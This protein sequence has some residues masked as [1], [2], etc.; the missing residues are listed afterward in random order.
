MATR[1]TAPLGAFKRLFS[2]TVFTEVGC[3]LKSLTFKRIF[4]SKS[5]V[6]LR[7][8][9]FLNHELELIKLVEEFYYIGYFSFTVHTHT[10]EPKSANEPKTADKSIDP[11][12]R[13]FTCWN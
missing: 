10:N 5:I 13:C 6:I 2:A 11:F 4:S 7:L 1:Y 3:I 12:Q 8:Y 9:F